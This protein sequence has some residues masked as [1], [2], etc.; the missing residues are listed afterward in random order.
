LYT[1]SLKVLMISASIISLTTSIG[2][3]VLSYYFNIP[4]G[5]TIILLAV[6][7]YLIAYFMKKKALQA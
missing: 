1:K 2:G 6:T 7:V 4:S 5:A 3:L